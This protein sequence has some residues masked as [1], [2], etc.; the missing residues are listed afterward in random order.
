M[1]CVQISRQP[2]DTKVQKKSTQW[3]NF[4]YPFRDMH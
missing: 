3:P 2:K 1:T 4:I